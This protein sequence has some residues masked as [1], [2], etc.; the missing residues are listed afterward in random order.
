M[1]HGDLGLDSAVCGF[2]PDDAQFPLLP[3]ASSSSFP[4]LSSS[5]QLLGF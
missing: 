4:S 1:T 2:S 3:L 5:S